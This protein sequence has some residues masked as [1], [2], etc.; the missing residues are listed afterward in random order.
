MVS[1]ILYKVRILLCL[2][3][4]VHILTSGL[5]ASS[6]HYFFFLSL[7]TAFEDDRLSWLP[8]SAQQFL[9]R[10]TG[11][12]RDVYMVPKQMYFFF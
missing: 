7:Q 6:G 5:Y 2:P 10:M 3:E 12:G 4:K 1:C 8:S 11:M 9:P